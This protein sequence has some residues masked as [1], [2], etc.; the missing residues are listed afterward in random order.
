MHPHSPDLFY[1]IAGANPLTGASFGRDSLIVAGQLV[2]ERA[3]F[4]DQGQ[5][6]SHF[7][8]MKI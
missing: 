1:L 5:Q 8:D 3:I 7:L 2:R 4:A 6:V